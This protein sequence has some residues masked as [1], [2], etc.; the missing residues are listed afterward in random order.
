MALQKLSTSRIDFSASHTSQKT[1]A[2][3]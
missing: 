1:M 2:S 3:T